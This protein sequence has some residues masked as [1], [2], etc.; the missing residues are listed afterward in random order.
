MGGTAA[1]GGGF[2]SDPGGRVGAERKGAGEEGGEEEGEGGSGG[3]M[4][5]E[6]LMG[7]EGTDWCLACRM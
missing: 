5:V 2:Q 6:G 3:L 4:E 1:S 7:W